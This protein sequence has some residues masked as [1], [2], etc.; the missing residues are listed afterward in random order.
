[1]VKLEVEEVSAPDCSI[2]FLVGLLEP[3]GH[4]GGQRH[5]S[6]IGNLQ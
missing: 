2:S 5:S 1:M 4:Q 3:Q 6:R